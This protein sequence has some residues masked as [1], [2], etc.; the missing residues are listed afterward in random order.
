MKK[1]ITNA[2]LVLFGT[3]CATS[4]TLAADKPATRPVVVEYFTSQGCSSCPPADAFLRDDLA[5]R[6]DVL[7]LAFHVDYW[8]DLGW[9]DTF[10]QHAFTKR[11]YAYKRA[12]SR[13]GEGEGRTGVY[14][15]QM[16]VDGRF[17]TVG[18]N[19]N[20][21][22]AY[23]KTAQGTLANVPITLT[24]NGGE[25][26]LTIAASK[27]A[28]T[29]A[30]L[31]LVNYLQTAPV[32]ITRGENSGRTI[33]YV[34]IVRDIQPIAHWDG[35]AVSLTLPKAK[36]EGTYVALLQTDHMG[37]ILGALQIK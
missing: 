2:A 19:R 34:N 9:K 26:G 30:T 37:S 32:A 16:V 21:V 13:R 31:L 10:S 23:I 29:P 4:P 12:L 7:A 28:A 11:Q 33:T 5:K 25:T 14:T 6:S 20:T 8:D 15:P 18:S 24:H 36:G 27:D 3:I 22:N 1:P 35:E 17:A